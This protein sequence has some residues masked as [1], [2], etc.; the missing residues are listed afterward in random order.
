MRK[1]RLIELLKNKKIAH[2]E[3][4]NNHEQSALVTPALGGRLLGVFMDNDISFLWANENLGSDW[5]CGGQRTWIAPEWQDKSFYLKPDRSTWF[6]DSRLDPGNYGITR[7]EP[8][9]MVEMDSAIDITSVD[10]TDYQLTIKRK[11]SL[12][13]SGQEQ[14]YCIDTYDNGATK[15][16]SLYIEQCLKNRGSRPL[17]EELGLWSILQIQP[18]GLILVPLTDLTEKLFYEYYEQF[19]PERL[20][21]FKSGVAIFVDG[22]KRYKLGFPPDYASG[23]IGY[24]SRFSA[25]TYGLV[26]KFFLN[27]PCTKYVDK[28]K[29]DPRENGD[30]IQVYNHFEGGAMAFA[31]LECHAPAAVLAPEEEQSFCVDFL[32]CAGSKRSIVE[33]ADALLLPNCASALMKICDTFLP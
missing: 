25:G 28:P 3:L 31:E 6:V 9:S 14:A 24:L 19:P 32:F 30:V 11:I 4:S 12:G 7:H 1:S 17:H 23:A 16:F 27:A 10:G 5:N 26:I 2:L 21:T 33:Q 29:S 22:T 18:P 15:H 20:T 13:H 8:G